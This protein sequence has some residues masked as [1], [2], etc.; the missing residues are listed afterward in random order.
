MSEVIIG[1]DLAT[2]QSAVA[3][4]DSGSP[5]LHADEQGNWV[6]LRAVWYSKDGEIKVG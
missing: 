4:V 3:V 2:T 1:V 5:C 6:T